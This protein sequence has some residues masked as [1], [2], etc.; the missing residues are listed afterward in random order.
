MGLVFATALICAAL[1]VAGLGLYVLARRR[2]TPCSFWRRRWRFL[3]HSFPANN[4]HQSHWQADDDVVDKAG[5]LKG[6]ETIRLFYALKQRSQF[7]RI[8]KG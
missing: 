5:K 1:S 6:R 2:W 3:R 4:E 7:N 8:G